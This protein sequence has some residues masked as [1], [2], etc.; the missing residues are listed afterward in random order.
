MVRP[1]LRYP[2]RLVR[3]ADLRSRAIGTIPIS[4]QF[5]GPV[6]T[7]GR[8]RIEVGEHC[9][10]GRDVFLETCEQGRIRIGENVRINTGV[11]LVSY[12]GI[13]IGNDCLIG[14][15]VSI[16]DANHGTHPDSVMRTQPHGSLPISIGDDVWI[17]RGSVILKGVQIGSGAVVGANSVVTHDIEPMVIAG[18]VPAKIIRRRGEMSVTNLR[19]VESKHAVQKG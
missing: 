4:T 2:I 12:A 7:G 15:Y 16:R 9:R 1:V 13:A 8:I 19:F 6:H 11:T 5:D 17:G 14:E 18:G 10:F 3:L